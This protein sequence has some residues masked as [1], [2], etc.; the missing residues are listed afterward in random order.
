MKIDLHCHTLNCKKGDGPKREPCVNLFK[1][2]VELAE[3]N[4]IAITNHN[5][6]DLKQYQ[7]FKDSV[8]EVCDVWPGIELD[9]KELGN[10]TGHVLI[11][12][13]PNNIEMFNEIVEENINNQNPNKYC[14]TVTKMC[15]LFNKLNVVYIPH[16]FK[17]NQLSDQD[18]ELLEMKTYSKKRVL[19]E[20]ADIKSLGVLNANGFK[21]VIGSDVKDWNE[22]EKSTFAELKYNINGYENFLK[23]LDKD[24][25]FINDLITHDFYDSVKV[26]GDH[27]NKKNPFQIDLYNDVNIIF[28]DKGS[29]KTE[30]LNSLEEYFKNSKGINPVR[31][32]GGDKTSWFSALMQ[33]NKKYTIEDLDIVDDSNVFDSIENYVDIIPEK[34]ENYVKYFQNKSNNK[35]RKKLK[36]LNQEKIFTSNLDNYTKLNNE[37]KEIINFINKF[38]SYEVYKNNSEK[39]IDIL[40]QLKEISNDAFDLCMDEWLNRKADYLV[41]D[42]IDKYNTYVSESDGTPQN[43]T[44]TGFYKF[45]KNRFMLFNSIDK[46]SDTINN[47]PQILKREYIGRIGQKGDG[48]LFEE[49]GF[50]NIENIEKLNYKTM[51]S[52]KTAINNFLQ[53]LN[54]V[55]D[56]ILKINL[57]D[58]TNQLNEKIKEND[59]RTIN[60]FLY[61][62]P[63]DSLDA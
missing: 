63:S 48:V 41:D 44:E 59:I 43:P 49:L 26:Y 36:I 9:V 30:I 62:R 53:L 35:K 50:V 5:K 25:T 14:I 29:G 13:N 42:A 10:K 55:T 47:T 21:S 27:K 32:D 40:N 17:E 28:G 16:Y 7:L 4:I 22:Y 38:I 54:K 11:I 37:Y 34:I 8:K 46:F 58:I 39:Y 45:C 57:T 51:Y 3:V 23:L 52:G 31:F 6:F 1:E 33:P 60:K 2:K 19:H 24:V 18:L 56:S 61:A 12:A 15:E 20:P